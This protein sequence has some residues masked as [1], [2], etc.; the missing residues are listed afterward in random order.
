[1]GNCLSATPKG[2]E[3][4]YFQSECSISMDNIEKSVLMKSKTYFSSLISYQVLINRTK[5]RMISEI[6]TKLYLVFNWGNTIKKRV[7]SYFYIDLLIRIR[8]L[9]VE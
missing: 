8:R 9:Y 1:M 6:P 2:G 3:P 5:L 4:L 7:I